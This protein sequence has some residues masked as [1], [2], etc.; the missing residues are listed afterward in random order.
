MT[1]EEIVIHLEDFDI[2][3]E[4]FRLLSAIRAAAASWHRYLI[5]AFL[6][7]LDYDI[8]PSSP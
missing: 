7:N 6:S 5:A 1:M 2:K 4:C 8:L 3:A